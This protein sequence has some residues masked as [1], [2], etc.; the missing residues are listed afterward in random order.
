MAEWGI[1]GGDISLKV[2][3]NC[4]LRLRVIRSSHQGEASDDNQ[5]HCWDFSQTIWISV[6]SSSSRCTCKTKSEN[7]DRRL[8]LGLGTGGGKETAW[9]VSAQYAW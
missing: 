2:A 8:E 7:Q 4:C 9:K 3:T 5:I 6:A 1:P